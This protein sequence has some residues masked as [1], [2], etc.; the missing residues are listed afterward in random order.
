MKRGY[1][2]AAYIGVP[3]ITALG[4]YVA[5]SPGIPAWFAQGRKI[6][7][8]E[9]QNAALAEENAKLKQGWKN[10]HEEHSL[11]DRP[12]KVKPGTVLR[13]PRLRFGDFGYK[14]EFL[15]A[16]LV[17]KDGKEYPYKFT[18]FDTENQLECIASYLAMNTGAYAIYFPQ[19]AKHF[20]R[21]SQQRERG[22][23]QHTPVE[24]EYYKDNDGIP[25]GIKEIRCDSKHFMDFVPL[26]AGSEF[27][28]VTVFDQA[29]D[30]I[31]GQAPFSGLSTND[32]TSAKR[33]AWHYR[34][35]LDRQQE[36]AIDG[37]EKWCESMRKYMNEKA[38]DL[39]S[40]R[41][42]QQVEVL[43]SDSPD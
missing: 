16:V 21:T 25:T 15:T 8:L 29:L 30:G 5:S 14:S 28:P 40:T 18:N 36:N 22:G 10:A 24:V 6:E 7:S 38:E 34:N 35:K 27:K 2:I 20:P 19:N 26:V 1:K 32:K 13:S 17:D 11:P 31:T 9:H 33:W 43:R 42:D 3:A 23:M 41:I 37:M 39:F 4:G 12:L